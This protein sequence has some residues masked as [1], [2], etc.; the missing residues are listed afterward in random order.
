VL[1]GSNFD[2]ANFEAKTPNKANRQSWKFV[3]VKCSELS[4]F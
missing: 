4:S 2:L 3:A 1:K